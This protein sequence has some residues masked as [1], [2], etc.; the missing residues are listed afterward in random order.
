MSV[1]GVVGVLV[2]QGSCSSY[3][4]R[5]R[6]CGDWALS[7]DACRDVPCCTTPV[8]Y[9]ATSAADVFRE[10]HG[11]R[12]GVLE[13]DLGSF[14]ADVDFE[15]RAVL[16]ALLELCLDTGPQLDVVRLRRRPEGVVGTLRFRP[17]APLHAFSRPVVFVET[18]ADW[19]FDDVALELAD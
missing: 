16:V 14:P 11:T 15:R 19:A 18:P 13:G 12:L 6:A 3:E 7:D 1:R 9:W 2:V 10:E 8:T 17:A 4:I 5:A